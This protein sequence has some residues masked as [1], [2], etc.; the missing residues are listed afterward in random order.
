MIHSPHPKE[1]ICLVKSS[2]LWDDFAPFCSLPPSP[3]LCAGD[4]CPQKPE[5]KLRLPFCLKLILS[6][7]ASFSSFFFLKNVSLDWLVLRTAFVG[8][9][10]PVKTKCKLASPYNITA[11]QKASHFL[12]LYSTA[13]LETKTECVYIIIHI[14][15]LRSFFPH[16]MYSVAY[17]SLPKVPEANKQ[18]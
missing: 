6:C 12:R 15:W 3:L 9:L 2:S 10:P 7:C 14:Q 17:I 8:F 1:T 16:H 11:S 13:A 18:R 4:H 5:Q